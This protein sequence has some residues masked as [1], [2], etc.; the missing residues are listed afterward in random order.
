MDSHDFP[1]PIAVWLHLAAV[2]K[3]TEPYCVR[4]GEGTESLCGAGSQH[5]NETDS[6]SGSLS[7]VNSQ[8]VKHS[9]PMPNST[10]ASGTNRTNQRPIPRPS[11]TQWTPASATQSEHSPLFIPGPRGTYSLSTTHMQLSKPPGVLE[12]LFQER[13]AGKTPRH[14]GTHSQRTATF[15]WKHLVPNLVPQ[16]DSQAVSCVVRRASHMREV[17][18]GCQARC[19]GTHL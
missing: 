5:T 16:S 2:S 19:D 13:C 18:K 14:S 3:E 8:Y 6:A 1:R 15:F 11:I 9:L 10:P 12:L 17:W 7:R 4:K